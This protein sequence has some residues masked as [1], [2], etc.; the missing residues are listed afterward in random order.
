MTE[1]QNDQNISRNR[2]TALDVEKD[3]KLKDKKPEL[4][5]R[6]D[7]PDPTRFGDWEKGGKAVDF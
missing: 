6:Q 7:G 3:P 1:K 4:G 2:K 5:G